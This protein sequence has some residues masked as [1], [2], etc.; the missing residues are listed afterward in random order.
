MEQLQME[1]RVRKKKPPAK[2]EFDVA[3]VFGTSKDDELEMDVE[4]AHY[5]ARQ[6]QG[7]DRRA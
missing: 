3:R 1:P 4:A 6:G 2:L 5:K 7:G